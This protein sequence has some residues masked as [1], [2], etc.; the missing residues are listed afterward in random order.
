MGYDVLA[1][2]PDHEDDTLDARPRRG[3]LA[4]VV[5]YP[6]RPTDLL[7]DA[8]QGQGSRDD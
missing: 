8:A 5:A 6:P 1:P 7:I 2:E 4:V 3:E